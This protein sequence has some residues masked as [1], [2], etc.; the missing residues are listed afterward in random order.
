MRVYPDTNIPTTYPETDP[1]LNAT[2]TKESALQN[3]V[4]ATFLDSGLPWLYYH[5]HDSRKNDEGFP[6]TVAIHVPTGSVIVAELKVGKKN[7]VTPAQITWLLAWSNNP[8][9]EVYL[10]RPSDL[11]ELYEA[12]ERVH[13]SALT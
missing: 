6:D 4:R 7:K 3:H 9:T 10:L 13:N 5:T 1:V 2:F 12:M 8:C 11:P